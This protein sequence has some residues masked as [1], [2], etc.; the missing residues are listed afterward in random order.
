MKYYIIK[1]KTAHPR[2]DIIEGIYHY[3]KDFMIV[4]R[5][6]DCDIV[7]LQQGWAKSKKAVEE[8]SY[9]MYELGKT[10]REGSYYTDKAKLQ[11]N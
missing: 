5:I 11:L 3:D 8:R 2:R 1:A 10:C 4:S 9:A 6:E 7:I